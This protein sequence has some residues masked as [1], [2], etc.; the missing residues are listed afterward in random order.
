MTHR[1]EELEYADGAIYMEDGKV[2]SYGDPARITDLIKDKQAA[3]INDI[4][5]W[6]CCY[7]LIVCMIRRKKR[8]Q[9]WLIPSPFLMRGCVL[10][11]FWIIYCGHWFELKVCFH[12]Q[13]SQ[14]NM[15]KR[16]L[17]LDA[18]QFLW[19]ISVCMCTACLNFYNTTWETWELIV[20]VGIVQK[21]NLTWYSCLVKISFSFLVLSCN[22]PI[23]WPGFPPS[24]G[25]QM[26]GP[27]K[28]STN[29]H[30]CNWLVRLSMS[31]ENGP[32]Q[33]EDADFYSR[34]NSGFFLLQLCLWPGFA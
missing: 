25:V 34:K 21:N 6:H 17:F 30:W 9:E 1:L 20:S 32:M 5:C 18:I 8:Q 26:G 19:S 3:Y 24:L 28:H 2:I 12:D 33:S 15:Y 13:C 4:N 23:H 31:Y 10:P 29:E 22:S 27:G 7:M 14:C 11:M 16:K